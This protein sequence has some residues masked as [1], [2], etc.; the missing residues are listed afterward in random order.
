MSLE[1]Y[2]ILML[3]LTIS[4]SVLISYMS[5]IGK[6]Q[7]TQFTAVDFIGN[8]IFGAVVGGSI[9]NDQL[10]MIQFVLL[11]F[12]S[13]AF[14]LVLNYLSH[15]MMGFRAIAIGRP[16]PIIRRGKFLL[17]DIEKNKRKIDM[18]R[19]LSQL[20]AMGY[21]SFNEVFYAE[22]EPDGQLTAIKDT[23]I[24]PSEIFIHNGN[25]YEHRLEEAHILRE[26]LESQLKERQVTIDD[27]F[28][29]EYY[30]YELFVILHNGDELKIRMYPYERE[31]E[32]DEEKIPLNKSL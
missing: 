28:L 32:K 17:E 1:F 12:T 11:L 9:Y 20:H 30:H 14:M 25:V 24:P 26:R 2:A 27:I 23:P 19:I 5:F 21:H 6:T 22:V 7:L 31:L 16:I 8:F 29:A 15:R 10:P 4:F 13:V 18:L 3:K